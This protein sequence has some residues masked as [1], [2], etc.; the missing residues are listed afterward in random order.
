MKTKTILNIVVICVVCAVTLM[1]GCLGTYDASDAS[2]SKYG[3]NHLTILETSTEVGSISD[4]YV[5][6][7]I[8]ND[9]KDI[10]YGADIKTTVY[11]KNG[12][13]ISEENG[14]AF[15]MYPG[16]TCTFRTML[17]GQLYRDVAASYD[18]RRHL[19]R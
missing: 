11:D 1:S 15:Q 6:G 18:I 9:G 17:G 14:R 3:S 16:E 19:E 7:T 5:M 8:R 2:G 4:M 12:N 10:F 13:V